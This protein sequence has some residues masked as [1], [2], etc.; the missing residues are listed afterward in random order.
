MR[1]VQRIVEVWQPASWQCHISDSWVARR[2]LA[3]QGGWPAHRPCSS[4]ESPAIGH[5][6]TGHVDGPTESRRNVLFESPA[7]GRGGTCGSI[8][9]RVTERCASSSVPGS[10]NVRHSPHNIQQPDLSATILT[11]ATPPTESPFVI[12]VTIRVT[13]HLPY[14]NITLSRRSARH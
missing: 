6:R 8:S 4:P 3:E 13:Q 2:A 9:C 7:V 5:V 10:S 12:L 1:S 14:D 11:N